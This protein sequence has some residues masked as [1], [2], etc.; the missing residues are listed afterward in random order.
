MLEE[1]IKEGKKFDQLK[2]TQIMLEALFFWGMRDDELMMSCKKILCD[3]RFFSEKE[4]KKFIKHCGG[5]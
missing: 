3:S 1:A 5:I 2:Q 4:W